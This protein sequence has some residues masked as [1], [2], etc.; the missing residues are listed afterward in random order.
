MSDRIVKA[1]DEPR[2]TVII[3]TKDRAHYLEKTLTTCSLQTYANLEIIVSDDGS[4]D[5]T[6]DVVSRAA[7]RDSRIRYVSPGNTVG[8]RDNFEFVL[9]QVRP[10]FVM[11]LGGDD[12]LLPGAIEGMLDAL[13][14]TGQQLLTWPA[15]VFSYAGVRTPGS[16]L[17][18]PLASGLRVVDSAAVLARQAR[19]LSYVTDPELP[20]FYVKGVV[21][22]ELVERVR[23]R[24]PEHRFYTCSTPD[25]YSGIVLAGEVAQYAY[26]GTPFSVYG[27]SPSSQG[28]AYLSADEK[29]KQQSA[30]FF[31]LAAGV[32]MH[33]E[34]ASQP[35]S[36]LISVM[37]ADFLLHARDLPGWPGRFPAIDYATL[38]RKALH[39]LSH[40]LY[41]RPRVPRELE[42]LHRI[43]ERHGLGGA[44]REQVRRGRRSRAK[45]PFAGSGIR[46]DTLFFD[47][48][49]FGIHDIVDA[50]FFCR[51]A[52]SAS[53][54]VGLRSS[55]SALVRSIRYR[56]TSLRQGDPFPDEA[57]WL[58]RNPDAS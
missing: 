58:T 27:A 44:F 40:G 29:A 41:S 50:V 43:A 16:Q 42:I 19:D 3:P 10:G 39:E 45:P 2:F 4:T 14:R 55:V 20:M 7:A 17:L 15:P 56:L 9:D 38:L 23:S 21:A 33:A 22:T 32:P 49:A 46:P 36:P 1:S 28:A 26:S 35:Y 47:G 48:E 53:G 13:R 52:R 34:L 8:M 24:S 12:G 31:R 11:A 54:A 5:G 6:R 18:L 25:G 37:T 57:E 51:L 30:D